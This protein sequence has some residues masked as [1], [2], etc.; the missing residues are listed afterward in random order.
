MPVLGARFASG[1]DV[2]SKFATRDTRDL[3]LENVS[4]VGH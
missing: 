1:G 3:L 2:G 4:E